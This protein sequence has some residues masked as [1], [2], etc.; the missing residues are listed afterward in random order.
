MSSPSIQQLFRDW[1][2]R[3]VLIPSLIIMAG[4]MADQ[5]RIAKEEKL[6]MLSQRVQYQVQSV[7]NWIMERRRTMRLISQ[8]AELKSLDEARIQRALEVAQRHYL[9]FDSLSY[10]DKNGFF[11]FSTLPG[12]IQFADASK[13]DYFLAGT[14]GNEFVSDVVVGRNSG[15][16]IINFSVPIYDETGGFQGVLLAS[17]QTA[18][19]KLMLAND[20]LGD[21]GEMLVVNRDG[22]L[23]VPPDNAAVLKEQGI[24]ESSRGQPLQLSASALRKMHTG[25]TDKGNWRDY[26]DEDVLGA[27]AYLPERGWTIIGSISEREVLLPIY[28]ELAVMA[29]LTMLMLLAILPFANRATRRIKQ[30]LEWLMAESMQVIHADY[31]PGDSS[32]CEQQMPLELQTLCQ[33]FAHMRTTIGETVKLLRT[34]EKKLATLNAHLEEVVLQ[35]TSQLQHSEDLYR[36]L[37]ENSPDITSRLDRNY[38][39]VYVN[40]AFSALTGLSREEVVGKPWDFFLKPE[41]RPLFWLEKMQRV[42]ATG[43]STEIESWQDVVDVRRYYSVRFVPEF[44]QGGQVQTLLCIVRDIT[45]E[46]QNKE[47]FYQA[48][49]TNPSMMAII[50]VETQRYM[51]VNHNFMQ[52]LGLARAEIVGK[53]ITELAIWQEPAVWEGLQPLLAGGQ[54]LYNYEIKYRLNELDIGDALLTMNAVVIGQ[55]A[56][57][58]QVVTDI[59][60]KKKM[61]HD[62]ARLDQLNVVGEMAASIGHE[63][64]NPMTT[65]R[66]YLQLF[67]RRDTFAAYHE[68]FDL[69]MGEL[70]RANAIITEFLSLAKNRSIDKKLQDLNGII[71]SLGPLVEAEALLSGKTIVFSL[72]PV[73]MLLMVDKKEICQL[74][75]NLVINGLEAMRPGQKLEIRTYA[76][77]H[78]HVVLEVIDEG[79]GIP[80]EIKS[81]LGTPFITTK[82]NGT[83]LG[84]SVCYRIV[85]RHN[86]SIEV[87]SSERGTVFRIAFPV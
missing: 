40:P 39:Y 14:V 12:G 16:E 3:L 23:I 43:E 22:L 11:R 4:F 1:T 77:Q 84:L 49:H 37:V 44:E 38:C 58:L 51:D 68:Q 35:R 5:V 2:M 73:L 41:D 56:C 53:R 33:R 19:L 34:N 74:L 48:F 76:R 61:E 6:A 78:K 79:P 55:Q 82:E 50:N 72:E 63:V 57:W 66:G 45:E 86:G 59:T 24:V 18:T 75:L 70:D 64:R 20:W 21:T 28:Q 9:D 42:F 54:T 46:M 29:G 32:F 30:P 81:K 69:M 8:Q 80:P 13:K 25:V 87:D 36:G 85:Q 83:G 62:M 31:Q 10:I 17:V 7:D 15:K 26:A 65:V 67:K 71:R 27:T 52:A 60:D 47:M